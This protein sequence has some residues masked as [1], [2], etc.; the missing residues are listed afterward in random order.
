MHTQSVPF[1]ISLFLGMV[2]FIELGRRLGQR[3]RAADPEG[4]TVGLSAIDG[5]VFALFGL[6]IAFT[7]SGAASRFDDRRKLIINEANDISTAWNY[8]D[9]L[10]PNEQSPMR[11]LFRRY[12]DARISTFQKLPDIPAAKMELTV[13]LALQ[14]QIWARAVAICEAKGD[15][16]T[17]TL[18]LGA[19]N[20]MNN[21][22]TLRTAA[23]RIHPPA[24]IFGLLFALGLC[25]AL[26][27]GYGMSGA[28]ARSWAHTFGFAAVIGLCAYVI[29]DLEYPRLGLIR[30]TE[31]DQ[32]MKDVRA[33]MQ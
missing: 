8:V 31:T 1:A 7:F 18:F 30:V 28:K 22:T 26:L 2:L 21:I 20:E 3:M 14:D 9:L 12:T 19:L 5:A 24:T 33:T 23:A 6:L 10:P 27:A 16:P 4:A 29:L 17:T 25:S 32:V 11:D 13:S 15:S